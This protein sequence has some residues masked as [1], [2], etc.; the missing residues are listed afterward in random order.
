[1]ISSEINISHSSMMMPTRDIEL[2]IRIYFHEVTLREINT[3]Q[4]FLILYST[5]SISNYGNKYW[6]HPNMFSTTTFW[7][8]NHCHGCR[9]KHRTAGNTRLNQTILY[10]IW[11]YSHMK[12]SLYISCFQTS[13]MTQVAIIN[14]Q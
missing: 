13:N 2:I 10:L 14:I 12:L 7:L 4:M 1:L 6:S 9:P 8:V 3:E 5:S 11:M